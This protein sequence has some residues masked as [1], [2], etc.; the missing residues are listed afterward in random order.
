MVK[1]QNIWGKVDKNKKYFL[2]AFV[3]WKKNSFYHFYD[4]AKIEQKVFWNI[5]LNKIG[6]INHDI[7]LTFPAMVHVINIAYTFKILPKWQN[8]AKSGNTLR[9]PF[10]VVMGGGGSWLRGR[11][12]FEFRPKILDE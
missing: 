6:N 1:K 10:L 8:F 5:S 12:K 11:E 4:S 7:W 3:G 9:E 2:E